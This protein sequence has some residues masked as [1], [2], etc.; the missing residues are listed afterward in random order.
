MEE[1]LS[2]EVVI[3][4]YS[5]AALAYIGDALIELLIRR[6]LIGDGDIPSRVMTQRAQKLVCAT[7]QSDAVETLL[8]LLDD[9]ETSVY[10]R[11][12][13][14]KNGSVPRHATPAQYARASGFECVFG[15]LH[16]TGNDERAYELIKKC[17]MDELR[18]ADSQ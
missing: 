13:N 15:F 1:S 14:M 6:E 10:K 12:R 3:S 8:P 2:R 4:K 18:D 9:Q 11:G 5:S 17:Y 16:L 7:R